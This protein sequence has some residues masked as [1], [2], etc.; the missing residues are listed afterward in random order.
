LSC[1][2]VTLVQPF[3]QQLFNSTEQFY[4]TAAS[5][6]EQSRAQSPVQRPTFADPTHPGHI[7]NMQTLYA[8]LLIDANSLLIRSMSNSELVDASGRHLQDEI[9]GYIDD[10]LPSNCDNSSDDI[11]AQ[12]SSLTVKNF[13]VY[14]FNG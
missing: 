11:R 10:A 12:F 4:K 14:G 2:S 13:R 1:S 3:D 5:I 9:T 6:I 8:T 7:N